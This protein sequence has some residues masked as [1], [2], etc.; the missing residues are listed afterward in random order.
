MFGSLN[1]EAQNENEGDGRVVLDKPPPAPTF[2]PDNSHPPYVNHSTTVPDPAP[3]PNAEQVSLEISVDSTSPADTGPRRGS[4]SDTLPDGHQLPQPVNPLVPSLRGGMSDHTSG[5]ALAPISA[6]DDVQTDSDPEFRSSGPSSRMSLAPRSLDALADE[7]TINV[8]SLGPSDGLSGNAVHTATPSASLTRNKQYVLP[9]GSVVS[10]KGLGRGRPGIKRGPRSSKSQ[11]GDDASPQTMSANGMSPPPL[12]FGPPRKKRKGGDSDTSAMIPSASIST[13]SRDSSEEYNPTATYTRSGRHTQKPQLLT[14]AALASPSPSSK[15]ARTN[16]TQ[17]G[18][19]QSPSS[20]KTHP[21]IK[22]RIYRGRE[23]FALCEHCLRG[24]GPPGNVIV[25]CDACN[26]CWHQ[27][28]H[29]P[30]VPKH[31]VS[32]SR[33]DWFCVD[34]DRILHGGK[35]GKKTQNKSNAAP[36]PPAPVVVDAKPVFAGPRIGGRLVPPDQKRAYLKTLSKEDLMSL[37]LQASDLAPDLPL[38]QTLQ[39]PVASVPQAQFTSTY[40]TPVSTT[41]AFG[42]VDPAEDAVDEG[43]DGYYDEHAALYPKPGNGVKLPPESED[44]HIMLE[45]KESKTFSHWVRGM[46]GNAF[47]G[48]GNVSMGQH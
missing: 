3:S 41:P 32:D 31:T 29:D 40:V 28:C 27:R 48:T 30:P 21:K 36:A 13:T 18:A 15:L 34:C 5:E 37:L 7:S 1:K 25:F 14:N 45:G 42:D 20:I 17:N 22:R 11:A 16:S 38:F 39:T 47:S 8:T 9:D 23:Q 4:F 46:G 24:H 33:A 44:L 10:G 6:S 19:S 43:Y 35:K 2:V 12:S 26:K